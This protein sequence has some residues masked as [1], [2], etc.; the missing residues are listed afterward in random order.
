MATIVNVVVCDVLCYLKH[1]FGKTTVKAMKS[2]L[3]DFYDVEVLCGAKNQL[4]D[5]ISNMNLTIKFPHIPRRRDGDNRIMREVDDI[6]S[7]FTVLDEHKLLENLP[8][9]VAEG[10]DSMPS[11][12]LYEGDL[13]VVMNLMEKMDSRIREFDVKLAAI[14]RDIN[15][16][17]SPPTGAMLIGNTVGSQPQRQAVN[18]IHDRARVNMTSGNPGNPGNSTAFVASAAAAE[19]AQS[20]PL[21]SLLAAG[22]EWASV[23]ASSPV[24]TSNRFA[25]LADGE[26]DDFTDADEQTFTDASRR[27]HRSRVKR[28]RQDSALDRQQRQIPISSQQQQQQQQQRQ[29]VRRGSRSVMVGKGSAAAN[30]RG[31]GAAQKL[32]KKA[33]FCVDNVNPT[34]DVDDLCTYVTNM[35]I[36][37]L[38]CYRAQPRR[39]RNETE[40]TVNRRAFRLCIADSD[41]DKLLDADKWPDSV[42]ISKWYHVSPEVAAERRAAAAGREDERRR[43]T[44]GA[45][46]V[47]NSASSE[48][49][50]AA[51][52]VIGGATDAIVVSPVSSVLSDIQQIG[53]ETGNVSNTDADDATVIY[54]N[55]VTTAD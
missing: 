44:A 50:A 41:R 47:F 22:T 53:M 48:M 45:S 52:L 19:P 43:D 40:Q 29:N 42:T 2:L 25:A 8:R 13:A 49:S 39:R 11:T 24:S 4:L 10:P 51:S 23:A 36:K 31:L 14:L 54:N 1:K 28:R 9:Y 35:S 21:T 46:A 5:D 30:D 17:R 7:L 16:L 6:Y 38:S 3:M 34:C 26:T 20:R 18:N 33:V 15:S 55:G 12:R 27:S 37:V 32:V